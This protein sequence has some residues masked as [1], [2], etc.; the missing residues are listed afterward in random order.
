MRKGFKVGLGVA[1]F[2]VLSLGGWVWVEWDQLFPNSGAPPPALR[3]DPIERATRLHEGGRTEDAISVL[4]R[5]EVDHPDYQEAQALLA[6]LREPIERREAEERARRERQLAAILQMAGQGRCLAAL[7]EV[8]ELGEHCKAD[9]EEGLA[10]CRERWIPRV[11]QAALFADRRYGR[12]LPSLWVRHREDPGDLDTRFM[13]SL[14]YRDLAVAALQ[15]NRPKLARQ[16]L[17]TAATVGSEGKE[18]DPDELLELLTRVENDPELFRDRAWRQALRR[19]R[20]QPPSLEL[21]G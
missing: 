9:C 16:R 21:G 14:A 5:V 7:A 1:V 4:E 13:L 8:Q 18:A 17:E 11:R 10:P 2:A 6:Q 19:A 3:F 20:P 15:Q 12:L